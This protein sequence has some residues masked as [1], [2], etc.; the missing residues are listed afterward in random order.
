MQKGPSKALQEQKLIQNIID[1]VTKESTPKQSALPPVQAPE[2]PVKEVKKDKWR[3]LPVDKQMKIYE[4]TVQP[5]YTTAL[6]GFREPRVQVY[7]R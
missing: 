4:N 7:A 2:S 3:S 1:R 6:R 5:P